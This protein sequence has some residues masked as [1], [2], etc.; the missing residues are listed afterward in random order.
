MSDTAAWILLV[1][2]ALLLEAIGWTTWLHNTKRERECFHHR[3]GPWWPTGEQKEPVE[4][5]VRQ[6]M[7]RYGM[8]KKFWCTL[9][10]KVWII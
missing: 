8:G 3:L 6:S 5:Y 7:I 9:C 2:V 1:I 4:S 10:G